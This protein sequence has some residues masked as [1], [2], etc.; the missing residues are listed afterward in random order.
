MIYYAS[1][2]KTN[3]VVGCLN[4]GTDVDAMNFKKETALFFAAKNGK[5]ATMKILLK[6]GAK[7]NR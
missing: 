4:D 1:I 7:P 2:G 3:K 5:Y 6:G